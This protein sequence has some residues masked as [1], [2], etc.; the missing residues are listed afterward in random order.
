MR[1]SPLRSLLRPL[2][3]EVF[4]AVP[5]PLLYALLLYDNE[6]TILDLFP[7]SKMS[8]VLIEGVS[9]VR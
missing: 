3:R 7:S 8:C 5:S 2:Y 6:T 4:D 1:M 9:I